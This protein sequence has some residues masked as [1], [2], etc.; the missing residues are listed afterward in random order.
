MRAKRLLK[1]SLFVLFLIQ[2]NAQTQN[3]EGSHV[4]ALSALALEN[5]AFAKTTT[6]SIT[7]NN[8]E[9]AETAKQLNIK[10]YQLLQQGDYSKAY[11]L[12]LRARELSLEQQD[13]VELARSLSNL[14]A[15]LHYLGDNE[16]ALVLYKQSLDLSQKSNNAIGIERA[17]NN[18][19]AIY[20]QLENYA[21]VRIYRE[22]QYQHI[23]QHNL[24]NKKLS[25]LISLSRL[26]LNLN[27]LTQAEDYFQQA[28]T[29]HQHKPD[30]FLHIFLLFNQAD[31]LLAQQNYQA[32]EKALQKAA[33]VAKEHQFNGLLV[34]INCS[35]AK[36][37]LEQK[38][39][40]Q[41]ETF[42]F[43]SLQQA[44][45]FTNQAKIAESYQLLSQL[46]EQ[47]DNFKL[48]LKYRDLTLTSQKKISSTK[49]KALAEIT[50]VERH[51]A[52]TEEMLKQSLQQKK[53]IELELNNSKNL[54]AIW[55]IALVCLALGIFFI[56]YRRSAKQEIIQQ[57]KLNNE[58]QQLD[59][60]KDR[61]LTNTSHELRTPLNGII[62]LSNII[63]D[64]NKDSLDPDILQS[65][66]LIEKS[67]VQLSHIVNDILDLAQL[68]S[69]RTKF[70][71]QE[72]DLISLISHVIILCQP[73]ITSP[74]VIINFAPKQNE[75][76]IKQDQQR[77]Q[78]ILFN[79]IGNAVKFTKQGSINIKSQLDNNQLSV[80]IS[81]TGIGIPRDKIDRVFES[82]EQIDNSNSRSISGSGL[83]L[84]ICHEL[85][86]AL[87]G[88]IVIHS[89]FE[90]QPTG[91]QVSFYL[92]I[93]H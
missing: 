51:V 86:T 5:E 45:L 81:D 31:L 48:A 49:V 65:I 50:R 78:Q 80:T 12:A 61:I 18:L 92:P 59:K 62:G 46:Y 41:A 79:L 83:G 66:K 33:T 28:V 74:Q 84:A 19:S 3:I 8:I 58:L 4:L 63:I 89:Q 11:R 6:P 9:L 56:A 15:N 25:I 47:Q 53:I 24:E 54:L 7:S 34:S 36:L 21:E 71:Y 91:T 1:I 76:I 16:K 14:A 44:Q 32:A 30:A 77:L 27:D 17:L 20:S 87:G 39:Y 40:S 38:L 85:I 52:Q 70:H 72:F 42:L 55:I 69:K 2:S 82:F 13:S 35:L 75:M 57:K 23:Y 37:Y 67:G 29:Q 93:K 64:E 73:L 68:K 90:Q 26:Y 60:L 88:K 22:K 10:A 43:T